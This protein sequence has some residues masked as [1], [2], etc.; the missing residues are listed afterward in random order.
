MTDLESTLYHDLK[1]AGVDEETWERWVFEYIIANPSDYRRYNRWYAS[2][3]RSEILSALVTAERAVKRKAKAF[4]R[5]R[6]FGGLSVRD[7]RPD[8]VGSIT[9]Y[10]DL[11]FES[12]FGM[13]RKFTKEPGRKLAAAGSVVISVDLSTSALSGTNPKYPGVPKQ[14]FM[15]IMA[16]VVSL[17][18]EARTRGDRVTI[19]TQPTIGK[20]LENVRPQKPYKMTLI[21]PAYPPNY[22]NDMTLWKDGDIWNPPR[23]NGLAKG[24]GE[25]HF[26]PDGHLLGHAKDKIQGLHR[27]L[28]FGFKVL[29][30]YYSFINSQDYDLMKRTFL[31]IPFDFVSG[32]TWEDY[33]IPITGDIW[34]LLQKEKRGL[35]I[36]IS[37]LD[38]L[39]PWWVSHRYVRAAH[40]VSD[41]V[42]IHFSEQDWGPFFRG[43]PDML[44]NGKP[45]VNY[46]N[47]N[48]MGYI[49]PVLPVKDMKAEI[50]WKKLYIKF[51]D[52][53]TGE[54][55][56]NVW[57][58]KDFKTM[59]D[60]ISDIRSI[61]FFDVRPLTSP[62][63]KPVQLTDARVKRYGGK[64][65]IVLIGNDV[66]NL[67]FKTLAVIGG[68]IEGV[69]VDW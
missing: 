51:K 6:R 32:V 37:S 27:T 55:F 19:I 59:L 60:L 22:P 25:V 13:H 9:N 64:D 38:T 56:S 49:Y 41:I 7:H 53:G 8:Y 47:V 61:G 52:A 11:I 46:V 67:S 34:S 39:A 58:L 29:S 10:G 54:E 30:E 43:E 16:T 35:T 21:I 42:C 17:I 44:Y 24:V 14:N 66:E 5:W 57:A 20:G 4:G 65:V 36:V 18:E 62:M 26:Q 50:V 1:P 12:P 2:K 33:A 31:D 40:R 15:N 48:H 45:M 68:S 63:A 69:K 23:T 3:V 28:S